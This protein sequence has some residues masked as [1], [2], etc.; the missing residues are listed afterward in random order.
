MLLAMSPGV[1]MDQ[2]LQI[3]HRQPETSKLAPSFYG[4]FACLFCSKVVP[5]VSSF[6]LFLSF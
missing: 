4:C 1:L 2:F 5:F 3:L 6:S